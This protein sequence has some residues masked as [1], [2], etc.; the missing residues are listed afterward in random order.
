MNQTIVFVLFPVAALVLV[1]SRRSPARAAAPALAGAAL[2][3]LPVWMG[4]LL[5]WYEPAGGPVTPP[6]LLTGIPA[7][8]VQFVTTGFWRVVGLEGFA[9]PPLLAAASVAGLGLLGFVY[10]RRLRGA[11]RTDPPGIE[12]LDLVGAITAAGAA[13][14]V[15]RNVDPSQL[16]YV[17]PV[18]P[19]AI[20]LVLVGL[21]EAA[22]LISRR[23]PAR[24]VALALGGLAVATTLFLARQ[25]RGVVAGILLEPD[26]R[27]PLRAITA[28]GYR[29]CHA[30]Y[31]TA[32]TLQFL[33]D[34]RVRFIPYHAPDRN[35]RLSAE[36]RSSPEPQCLVTDDGTVRRWLPSDAAQEGGPA[37]HR[38]KTR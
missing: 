27:A 9:P 10:R 19:A 6:W 28:E 34:E 12:G 35:R 23:V 25:A 13:L 22:R 14:F 16:R 15:L 5:G 1:R 8:L 18:L 7:R 36:L 3:Y 26:P 11:S 21:G 20:A 38:A 2:G 33:S 31:D 4:G 37:G 30:G 29:V 24:L 32:Y 17:T